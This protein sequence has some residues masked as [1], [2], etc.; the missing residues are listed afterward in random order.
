MVSPSRW[1]GDD[2][3]WRTPEGRGWLGGTFLPFYDGLTPSAQDEY[4][5]RWNA[6]IGWIT[7]FLHPD[8]DEAFADADEEDFGVRVEPLDF[9]KI[10]LG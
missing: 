5:R 6:P 10:L 3:H 9:R 4:C 1:P 8:L 7:M 2:P